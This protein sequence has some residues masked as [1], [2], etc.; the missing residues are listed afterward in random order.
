MVED[1]PKFPGVD[2]SLAGQW[3]QVRGRLRSEFGEA[4]FRS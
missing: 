3:A 4:T 1:S 2:G